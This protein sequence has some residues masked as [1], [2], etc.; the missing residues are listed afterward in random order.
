[1]YLCNL[2]LTQVPGER[3]SMSE[4]LHMWSVRVRELVSAD[5][6]TLFLYEEE[7]E[8]LVSYFSGSVTCTV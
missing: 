3:S 5:R 4:A 6:C 8:K 2:L 7:D 1:M